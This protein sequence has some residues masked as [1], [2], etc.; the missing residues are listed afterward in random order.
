[1]QFIPDYIQPNAP[2]LDRF[3]TK[4][5]LKSEFSKAGFKKIK[6]K[7]YNFKYSLRTFSDYWNGYLRYIAKPLREKI[8][9]LSKKQRMQLRGLVRKN[10]LMYTKKNGKIIFPWKI[11]IVT[12]VNT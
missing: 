4:T 3:G 7:E 12:A 6:I 9:K 8:S 2:S 1:M 10:T 11:L 5:L